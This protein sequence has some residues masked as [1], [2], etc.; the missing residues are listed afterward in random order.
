MTDLGDMSFKLRQSD[1]HDKSRTL[2][3]RD[4]KLD[5]NLIDM[6]DGSSSFSDGLNPE[7]VQTRKIIEETFGLKNSIATY[8]IC[9]YFDKLDGKDDNIID[10]K[11]LEKFVK[12]I[13]KN[14][15]AKDKFIKYLEEHVK[16]QMF[17]ADHPAPAYMPGQGFSGFESPGK[18]IKNA[19]D[20]Q[21]VI[22][23]ISGEPHKTPQFD[24]AERLNTFK[25]ENHKF[26][27]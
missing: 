18:Y 12:N 1:V 10:L 15:A 7:A 14:G 11:K 16:H 26:Q 6:K 2:G 13:S 17:L 24:W 8:F 5:L 3:K 27:E 4:G 21:S 20:I 25:L 9:N 22:D 19:D 23:Q